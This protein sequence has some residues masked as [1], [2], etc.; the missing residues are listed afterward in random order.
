MS[1]AFDGSALPTG[2]T[3]TGI[4][5]SNLTIRMSPRK[6]RLNSTSDFDSKPPRMCGLTPLFKSESSPTTLVSI[7]SPKSDVL[8]VQWE[9]Y[10]NQWEIPKSYR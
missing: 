7:Q 9:L 10:L 1:T 5:E 4:S 8:P 6:L 2:M 3:T